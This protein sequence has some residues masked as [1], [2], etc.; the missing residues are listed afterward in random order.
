MTLTIPTE[1]YGDNVRWF[2]GVVEDIKDPLELGRVRVRIYGIH[3][4]NIENVHETDLPWASVVAPITDPGVSGMVMPFGVQPGAQVFGIFMDGKTSQVPLVLG[5]IPHRND[6][7]VENTSPD[8]TF[9]PLAD[10]AN[11]ADPGRAGSITKKP[12]ALVGGGNEEKAF[13]F[14]KSYLETKGAVYAAEGAAGL[15]GNFLHEAGAGLNPAINE[16]KP[17]AGRGGLGLAQW[18]G[19]RRRQLENVFCKSLNPPTTPTDF[20]TQLQYV[21][22]ELENTHTDVLTGLKKA[23]TVAKATEVVFRFYETP[24]VVVDYHLQIAGKP[25]KYQKGLSAA[26]IVARY[27]GERDARIA[28]ARNVYDTFLA[29]PAFPAGPQ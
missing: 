7:T 11:L 28:D 13:N 19:P 18:T 24:A 9:V 1:F 6:L 5:S 17:I 15:V 2:L 25:P 23:K 16:K 27:E 21:A 14:L 10:G 26:Q 8:T 29:G 4:A 12:I 20:E 3:D 22:W